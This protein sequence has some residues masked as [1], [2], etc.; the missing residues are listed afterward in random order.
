M[1][2]AKAYI[3]PASLGVTGLALTFAFFL[4]HWFTSATTQDLLWILGPIAHLVQRMS[5]YA[6]VLDP[7]CGFVSA[8]TATII[9]PS[10]SGINFLL[11]CF[12]MV[13]FQGV[14]VSG[15]WRKSLAWLLTSAI[16]AYLATVVV[17]SV[18]ILSA[19][20]LY[21]HNIEYG[22][23]TMERVHRICGILIYYPALL[24][25]FYGIRVLF[26]RNRQ[27]A[28]RA[29]KRIIALL[30]LFCYIAGTIV[31]PLLTRKSF[32]PLFWEHSLVVTVLAALFTLVILGKQ[33]FHQP[34]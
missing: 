15:H 17:N 26:T 29:S 12:C 19:I 2:K 22:M 24:L 30:P 10:C 3:S 7:D 5:G 25:L 1:Y 18:R 6:F 21:Q 20:W 9:A 4:K 13:F 11:I 34:K 33:L 23:L 16:I 14:F 27:G 31:I 8:E 32:S 28:P